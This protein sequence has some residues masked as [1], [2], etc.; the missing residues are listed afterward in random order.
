[1]DICL[2]GQARHSTASNILATCDCGWGGSL[3]C[4][5]C[6]QCGISTACVACEVP[7][8]ARACSL[9]DPLAFWMQ[10]IIMSDV[11]LPESSRILLIM[12][13]E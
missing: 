6:M 8:E 2:T 5:S 9:E 12:V 11:S 3:R 4:P 13:W 10:G 1:M 7:H